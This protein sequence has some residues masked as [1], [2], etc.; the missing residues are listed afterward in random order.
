MIR[1]EKM[2]EIQESIDY[3]KVVNDRTINNENAS[4]LSV[5]VH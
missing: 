1:P 4:Y 3:F 5:V 2:Q